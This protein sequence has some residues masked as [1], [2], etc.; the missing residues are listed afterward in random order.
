MFSNWSSI[1]SFRWKPDINLQ[2]WHFTSDERSE[3]NYEELEIHSIKYL[4]ET[5]IET[6][7]WESFVELQR[8][9]FMWSDE[10][11]VWTAMDGLITTNGRM[12]IE[13]I[14]NMPSQ[15]EHC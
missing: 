8:T 3:E 6:V 2:S 5:H 1:G 4:L 10:S 14:I 11:S 9:E 7:Q 12:L 13:L 15:E